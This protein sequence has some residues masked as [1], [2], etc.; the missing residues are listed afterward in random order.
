MA[1]GTGSALSGC[2]GLS[3]AEIDKLRSVLGRYPQLQRAVLFGSRA[4]GQPRPHSDVDLALFGELD[5][6]TVEDI[7]QTL[8]ELPLPYLF[9]VKDFSRIA[10]AAL[11]AHIQRV[12]VEIYPHSPVAPASG[13]KTEA[14]A[15]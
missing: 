5:G 11:R 6:L 10:N 12:G 14:A 3:V 8:D 9:D 2:T 7:A 15:G 13:P 1:D 4:K